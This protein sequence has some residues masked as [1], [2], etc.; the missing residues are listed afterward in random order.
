MKEQPKDSYE[1]YLLK[2]HWKILTKYYGDLSYKHFYDHRLRYHM[3]PQEIRFKAEAMHPD[4]KTALD[5]KDEFY[6][7]LRGM[8]EHEARDFL[9]NYIRRLKKTKIKELRTFS[10]TLENWFDEI[11][12]SFRCVDQ[13]T[14]EIVRPHDSNAI[15]EGMNNKIKV[16]KCVS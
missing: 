1:Y 13:E 14:G 15:I 7:A 6:E 10:R 11:I 9:P 2:K 8:D 4:L 3:T 5:M 16:I 12:H